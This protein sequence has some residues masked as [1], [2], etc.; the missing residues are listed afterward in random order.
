MKLED[1]PKN[2]PFKAPEGYFERL[3]GVIQSR[4][5]EQSGVKERP[6]FRYALQ[7]A[8]PVVALAVAA[9]IYLVPAQPQDAESIL[10][11][12]STEELAAYL[13]QSEITTEELL[14]EMNPDNESAEAIESEVYSNFDELEKLEELDLDLNNL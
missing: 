6:Y 8:L 5:T 10:A 12:I 11:M 4:V 2:H 13:E 1:L 14:D 3:P 9:I 7:Y